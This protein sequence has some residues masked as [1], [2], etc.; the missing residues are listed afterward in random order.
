[1]KDAW[2]KW[3]AS[4]EIGALNLISTAEVRAAAGLV[5]QGRVFNL[6]Q[7]ISS[8]MPVPAHRL[9]VTHLMGRDGGDYSA[10]ARRPGGFQFSED[11]VVMPLHTGTHVDA[12]CHCWYDDAL[13]NSFPGDGVRSKGAERLGI[14]TMPP[15]VTRGV[16]LDFVTLNGAPLEDGTAIGAEALRAAIEQSGTALQPGDAVL[17]RTGWQESLAAR[18]PNFNAEPGIDLEAALVLAEAGVAM[19]AADNFA[20]EVLPFAEGTVF[21]VHQRLIRDFGIPLLEGLV[22]QPLSEAGSNEFLF[23]AA[24]LPIKGGTGSPITPIAVL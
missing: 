3:G 22:L 13:Y 10:G 12:L 17:L 23:M 24:P 16:L 9:G 20:V 6:A 1:M 8:A 4:D 15:V 5:R 19:V 2:G 11:T 14:Q 18:T 7:E 21:P